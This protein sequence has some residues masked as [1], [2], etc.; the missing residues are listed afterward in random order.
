M[1]LLRLDTYADPFVA[2]VIVILVVVTPNPGLFFG[3]ARTDRSQQE[4]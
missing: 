4:Y 3:I 1:P 2:V